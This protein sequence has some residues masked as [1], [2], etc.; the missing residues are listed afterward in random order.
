MGFCWYSTT[1]KNQKVNY[2]IGYGGQFIFIFPN[3]NTVVAINYNHDTAEGI[4]QSNVFFEKY[5][6]SIFNRINE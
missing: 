2:A 5:M 4:E 3:L 1:Y 6:P